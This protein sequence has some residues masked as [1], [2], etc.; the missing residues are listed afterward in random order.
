MRTRLLA[1][2]PLFVVA[3]LD[4]SLDFYRRVL[5]FGEP[6]VH[7]DPP[8]FAM[9]NRDGFDLMLSVAETPGAVTPN[10]PHGVWD[11]YLRVADVAAE[12]AAIT[13]AGATIVRGPQDTF[14]S[15]REIEVLDPDGH[16]ICLGQDTGD[17]PLAAGE[18]FEGT[19][20]VGSAK[21][22]LVLRIATVHGH[23]VARLDSLD[24]GA[25]NL[26]V[27]T[28]ARDATSMRFEM[29]SIGA[30][31]E[32]AVA[33]GGKEVAGHWTQGARTWPLTLRKN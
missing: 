3:D 8:C 2:T 16:R 7:G 24:Q 26:M 28:F 18:V 10:G 27:D 32:G 14:Y 22:R 30:R 20:D 29:K 19:L 31:F 1:V 4:R 12:A 9:L 17:E 5:A 23:E 15:M 6:S 33:A 13:A 21:L 11:V 25:M